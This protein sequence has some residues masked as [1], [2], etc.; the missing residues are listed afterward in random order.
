M[1]IFVGE[2]ASEDFPT[3]VAGET[4]TR[5]ASSIAN[6]AMVWNPT[7]TDLGSGAYRYA[8]VTTTAGSHTWTGTGS[9][10]GI[11]SINFDVEAST[12]VA[13]GVT[14]VGE[15]R[16]TLRR[17]VGRRIPGEQFVV[18]VATAGSTTSFTDAET[19]QGPTDASKG[20]DLYLID[21]VNAGTQ[22]RIQSSTNTGQLNWQTPVAAA[23]VAGDGAEL[24]NQRGIGV[25][26]TEVNDAIND[27]IAVLR[28]GSWVPAVASV[29]LPFDQDSP[30]V[31][32]P[33]ALTRGVYGLYYQDPVRDDIWHE[34]AGGGEDPRV[35]WWYD[36]AAGTLV[37]GG[38]WAGVIDT[39]ALRIQGYQKPGLLS[40]DTDATPL[41]PEAVI[42]E[43]VYQLLKRNSSRNP[44]FGQ[45]LRDAYAEKERARPFSVG[46]R[47]PNTIVF[48]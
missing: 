6:V 10:T 8:Y 9:A 12:S 7:F 38:S 36:R 26:A 23:V 2:T 33:A 3:G 31:V 1:T 46:R 30:T 15:T 16:L 45:F 41:D 42:T 25:K 22:R 48:D 34:V 5:I 19:L 13:A 28:R 18:L 29:V 4:F 20:A 37:V 24:W 27:A 32:I 43:A 40:A 44:E 21:G 47:A 17:E 39:S 11:F 14:S 35:G